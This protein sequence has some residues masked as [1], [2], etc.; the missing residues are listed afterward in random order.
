[1]VAEDLEL[2]EDAS[3]SVDA[4][5]AKRDGP[6][7]L[8]A[9]ICSVLQTE[10]PAQL[11][12][13]GV[14]QPRPT[15]RRMPNPSKHQ[16]LAVDN[17]QSVRQSIAVLLIS[18]GCDIVVAEDGFAALAQLRRTPPDVMISDLDMP[19]C[20]VLSCSQWFAV[21]FPRY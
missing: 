16:I 5:V 9:T 17:D 3:E 21:G 4:L 18:A 20:Q 7:F 12:G 11:D 6:H 8:L 1:M 19:V 13:A 2:P 14:E 10:Q 15:V